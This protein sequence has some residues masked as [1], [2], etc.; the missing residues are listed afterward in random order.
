SAGRAIIDAPSLYIA[1]LGD[2]VR[3]SD[4]RLAVG[5]PPAGRHLALLLAVTSMLSHALQL[6]PDGTAQRGRSG[7]LIITPNLDIR[8]RY[9]DLLFRGHILDDEFP[10]SRLRPDGSRVML[11]GANR[12]ADSGICFFLPLTNLP[13][14]IEFYP[15]LIVLDLRYA[16]WTARA[17][18]L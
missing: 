14:R 3:N 13:S 11:R 12:P 8:S 9:C 2:L 10:G 18:A 7:I 5:L 6:Q 4:Q 16:Q 17:T 1:G 15:A